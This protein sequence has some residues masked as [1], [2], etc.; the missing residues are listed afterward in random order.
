MDDEDRYVNISLAKR[1]TLAAAAGFVGLG[2]PTYY[3]MNERYDDS[4]IAA[5]QEIADQYQKRFEGL[6]ALYQ[7]IESL[8]AE[9]STMLAHGNRA[10]AGRLAEQVAE[11]R[12]YL[13]TGFKALE[14]SIFLNIHYNEA[15]F[16]E[17]AKQYRAAGFDDLYEKGEISVSFDPGQAK[18]LREC[19]ADLN[20]ERL[21]A[22]NDF[23]MRYCLIEKGHGDWGFPI[24]L[25]MLG[26]GLAA[27]MAGLDQ[28]MD[29][30]L[31]NRYRQRKRDSSQ[32][33]KPHRFG[34]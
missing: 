32:E 29:S 28:N 14:Q 33:R 12:V 13:D 25:G 19:Q 3:M 20:V 4:P 26:A 10:E 27:G 24:F 23:S 9:R 31:R 6:K 1:F 16:R 2:A 30:R 34:N 8:R 11:A 7:D 5:S 17:L 21:S 22:V 15:D 18:G